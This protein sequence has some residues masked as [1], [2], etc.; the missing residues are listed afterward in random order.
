MVHKVAASFD[1]MWNTIKDSLT[2]SYDMMALNNFCSCYQSTERAPSQKR[3]CI[4]QYST[5]IMKQYNPSCLAWTQISLPRSVFLAEKN[6]L[7]R[8]A[9]LLFPLKFFDPVLWSS[10]VVNVL[11]VP[12]LAGLRSRCACRRCGG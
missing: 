6:D 1:K 10:F 5:V 12:E 4:K 9:A 3:F 8:S 7:P 2:C 11:N